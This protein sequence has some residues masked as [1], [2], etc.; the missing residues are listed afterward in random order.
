MIDGLR[1][2]RVIPQ[3]NEGDRGLIT[4]SNERTETAEITVENLTG[5]PGR[6]G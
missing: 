3:T 1:L 4:K 5:K 2:K 6:C